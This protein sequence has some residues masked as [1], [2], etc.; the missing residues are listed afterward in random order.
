MVS[1]EDPLFAK[2]Q[3]E[4]KLERGKSPMSA[5]K[6]PFKYYCQRHVRILTKKQV[7][8]RILG[9]HRVPTIKVISHSFGWCAIR[10][11]VE[12]GT[13]NHRM[14]LEHKGLSSQFVWEANDLP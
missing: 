1:W 8:D 2:G 13:Q 5:E 6:K 14:E 10:N 4:C 9:S 11:G 12:R 3:R 7:T